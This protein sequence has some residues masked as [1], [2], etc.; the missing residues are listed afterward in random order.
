MIFICAQPDV[1]YFHWQIRM[2]FFN[3]E[4][5]GIIKKCRAIF[6]L[7]NGAQEPSDGLKKLLSLAQEITEYESEIED[8]LNNHEH[9]D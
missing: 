6:G 4:K 7:M 2:L 5:F 8:A 3:F 1:P 9:E